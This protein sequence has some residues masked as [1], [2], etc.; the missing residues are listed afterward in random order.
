VLED[1]VD[2]FCIG[3]GSRLMCDLE[4]LVDWLAI[5]DVIYVNLIFLLYKP[6]GLYI[7]MYR[8]PVEVSRSI[9]FY[10]EMAN[11]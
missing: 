4:I 11:F 1:R 8:V 2:I 9:N 10:K 6:K 3:R 5:Q 7:N